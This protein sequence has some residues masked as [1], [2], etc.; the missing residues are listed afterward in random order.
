MSSEQP[1]NNPGTFRP[2]A[3][4]D[5]LG[6]DVT[7]PG[8][9]AL[10][11]GQKV[12]THFTL[13]RLLG[14]G[15]MGMVWLAHNGNLNREVA[16]KFLPQVLASDS[17]V[18]D[19]LRR[20]TLRCLDL[21]HHHIV[22]VYGLELG[23][24]G[25]G[26][27]GKLA[28]IHMEFVDGLTLR[29]LMHKR[30]KEEGRPPIFEVREVAP[31]V[32]QLCDALHYAHTKAK[33]AHRDLKPSNIMVNSA[34]EAKLADFGVARKIVDN[35][36][37]VTNLI[38]GTGTTA[39]MSP[40]Q[41]NGGVPH[42]TDDVYSLGATIYELLTS[43]P[44]FFSGDMRHQVTQVAPPT[45]TERREQ[46]GFTNCEEI[47]EVWE[48]TVAACLAKNADERPQ[49]CEEVAK[50][51]KGETITAPAMT[52]D[53]KGPATQR[54]ARPPGKAAPSAPPPEEEP[55]KGFPLMPVIAGVVVLLAL[56]GGGIWWKGRPDT[57][58]KPGAGPVTP[59]SETAAPVAP[60]PAAPQFGAITVISEPPGAEVIFD[61]RKTLRTPTSQTNI[62]TGTH[63]LLFRLPNH[64][65]EFKEVALTNTGTLEVKVVLKR[66]TGQVS[67]E[68]TPDKSD[69]VITNT[70]DGSVVARGLTPF[71]TNLATGRYTVT[72][73][74]T[75]HAD[76]V[77][78]LTVEAGA[79]A[80]VSH[81][82][83]MGA[84]DLRSTPPGLAFE[85]FRGASRMFA[86]V[87][88]TNFTDL[89]AGSY[90]V[91]MKRE[92]FAPFD[93]T[94]AVLKGILTPINWNSTDNVLRGAFTALTTPTNASAVIEGQAP[95]FTPALFASLT[96]GKYTVN[97]RLEGYEPETRE[98][99]VKGGSTNAVAP[100]ALKRSTGTLQLASTPASLPYE[101][102]PVSVLGGPV[103]TKKGST[104]AAP[105][106]LTL[107]TG[108]YLVKLRRPGGWDE[109]SKEVT[110]AR[111]QTVPVAHE[112]AEGTLDVLIEPAS[113]KL[114]VN[115]VA[116]SKFPVPLPPGPLEIVATYAKMP[117]LITNVPLKKGEKLTLPLTFPGAV[118]ITVDPPE[119][120]IFVGGI[121]K[122]KGP[123]LELAGLPPGSLSFE[124]K[125]D[126]Y[127]PKPDSVSI[128]AGERT[129]KKVTLAKVVAPRPAPPPPEPAPKPVVPAPTPAP[130]PE[131]V[132]KVMTPTPAPAPKPGGTPT[133]ATKQWLNSL[134][135]EFV[136]V[137]GVK[138][139]MC[140][141]ETRVRDYQGF[142]KDK[143]LGWEPLAAQNGD[144]PAVNVTW[145]QARD[146]CAWLTDKERKA[147]TI[148][149]G[150][151]YRL[152]AD[153]EWSAAVG[154]VNEK[155][156][157]PS[158]RLKNSAKDKAPWGDTKDAAPPKGAGNY[159]PG[160]GSDDFAS[161]APVRSFKPNQ[162]GIH[163]LGGNAAEWCED[164]FGQSDGVYALRGGSWK[165]EVVKGQR[166]SNFMMLSGYR[167][168]GAIALDDTGFRIVLDPGK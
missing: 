144:H 67:V 76:K 118:G 148:A 143:E 167:F 60:V 149:A 126:G 158:D 163:D 115:G 130:K 131:Q 64:E 88:P 18:L 72:L 89:P 97:Y 78:P 38:V 80:Q 35:L 110:V 65:E 53:R 86:G 57:G 92:G 14:Q 77:E 74:R 161:T 39:Y 138:G 68:S 94:V 62:Q 141:H 111:Q 159:G 6:A 142:A 59:G 160:S 42:P 104:K 15:A 100:I 90:R 162:F 116:I 146:Y 132:A 17:L 165:T 103:E 26:A 95:R 20:E 25:T 30:V 105:E 3:F 125:R 122:G 155:G 47:P 2:P 69:F 43:K 153:V 66:L 1:T 33:V 117:N 87:T 7:S 61:G 49:S 81:A 91:T 102:Q 101:I 156:A 119:A 36:A 168:P 99:E 54:P 133:A 8:T 120:E 51:L 140:V 136:A 134:G 83:P 27:G 41:M 31:W 129:A 137:P 28:A 5:N 52:F 154:L 22:R 46:L 16:L 157:L 50:L 82:F 85:V 147:G 151:S 84:M 58:G 150:Q 70:A 10:G 40:Q 128:T 24:A 56:V 21:S 23:D 37:Q 4:D 32:E 48:R 145:Q 121:S 109:F 9:M 123:M 45:M 135:M 98:I 19:E 44:P 73:K 12:F 124:V 112:F 96:P 152:P 108:T 107:P 55:R 113:A 29:E 164:R 79:Q 166:P 139:L 127:H 114:T 71:K 75:D 106:F 13:K 63:T 93:D 34:G 11:V